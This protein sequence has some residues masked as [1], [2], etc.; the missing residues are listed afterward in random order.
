MYMYILRDLDTHLIENNIPRSVILFMDGPNARIR[1][2][3][4]QFSKLK[5]IQPWIL[6][7]NMTHLLQPFDLT[8]FCS[9]KIKL[10]QLAHIWHAVSCSKCNRRILNRFIA[11]HHMAFVCIGSS[12]VGDEVK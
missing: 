12:T 6:R 11:S 10:N 3:A 9:L 8:F 4:A 1:L 5:N 7:A 2:E